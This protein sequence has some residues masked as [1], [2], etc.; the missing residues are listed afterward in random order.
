MMESSHLMI[1][2]PSVLFWLNY[3]HNLAWLRA[4]ILSKSCHQSL[5]SSSMLNYTPYPISHWPIDALLSLPLIWSNSCLMWLCKRGAN[6]WSRKVQGQIWL[7]STSNGQ[8]GSLNPRRNKRPTPSMHALSENWH[9]AKLSIVH[10]Q[11]KYTDELHRLVCDNIIVVYSHDKY[12][13]KL[14]NMYV[15]I[16]VHEFLIS[17]RRG[18]RLR[19]QMKYRTMA[20]YRN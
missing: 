19:S 4:H 10:S 15:T 7:Y 17:Y 3:I 18:E 9:L 1:T 14:H 20:L 11:D 12:T 6:E 16:R 8:I 5:I 2:R 13:D